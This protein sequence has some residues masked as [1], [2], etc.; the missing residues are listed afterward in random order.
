MITGA[1]SRALSDDTL[2]KLGDPRSVGALT[3]A[4]DRGLPETHPEV[5]DYRHAAQEIAEPRRERAKSEPA[6]AQG[7]LPPFA[8]RALAESKPSSIRNRSPI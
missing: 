4:L 5:V 7:L 1:S 3:D 8:I 2:C 6:A